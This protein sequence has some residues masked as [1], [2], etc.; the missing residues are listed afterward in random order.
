VFDDESG[1]ARDAREAW[2]QEVPDVWQFRS[3]ELLNPCGLASLFC[4]FGRARL[5]GPVWVRGLPWLSSF[6]VENPA[7]SQLLGILVGHLSEQNLANSAREGDT[8]VS[9]DRGRI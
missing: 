8:G 9:G 4:R 1:D 6:E 7:V 2:R 3:L 5:P